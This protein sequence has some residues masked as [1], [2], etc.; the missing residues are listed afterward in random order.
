M[1]APSILPTS[2][3]QDTPAALEMAVKKQDKPVGKKFKKKKKRDEQLTNSSFKT[4]TLCVSEQSQAK[5]LL[6][7]FLLFLD[8]FY[9]SWT[10]WGIREWERRR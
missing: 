3:G 1:D 5:Q 9:F 7:L 2:Q 8:Y 4:W 6:G 10:I